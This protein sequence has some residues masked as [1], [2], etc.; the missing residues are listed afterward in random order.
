M[1]FTFIENGKIDETSR[2]LIRSQVM[3]GKNAGKKLS[4]RRPKTT[5]KQSER[6]VTKAL[7][8]YLLICND[9]DDDGSESSDVPQHFG[10]DLSYFTFPIK[11]RPHTRNLIYRCK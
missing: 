3:K 10:D 1:T 4:R 7:P 5:A 8:P 2:R 11:M 9:G 6:Q